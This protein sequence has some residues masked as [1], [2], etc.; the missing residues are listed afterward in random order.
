M[1]PTRPDALKRPVVQCPTVGLPEAPRTR[2]AKGTKE[3]SWE[4]YWKA[5]ALIMIAILLQEAWKSRVE[6]VNKEKIQEKIQE[7]QEVKVC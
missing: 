2:V 1:A 6:R 7:I 5:A 3:G 4:A